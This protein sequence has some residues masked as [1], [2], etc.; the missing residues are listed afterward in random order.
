V[1][2]GSVT[3]K[4]QDTVV[5]ES[6][7]KG[8]IVKIKS[9]SLFVL[10]LLIPLL[11]AADADV[12]S[13]WKG[14][15]LD[16]QHPWIYIDAQSMTASYNSTDLSSVAY[17]MVHTGATDPVGIIGYNGNVFDYGGLAASTKAYA[18]GDQIDQAD[19]NWSSGPGFLSTEWQ[20][21]I[22]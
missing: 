15:Q 4:Q 12:I 18:K 21:G 8:G 19:A 9:A 1:S 14:F 7:E 3:G 10:I 6:P 22:T 5:P 20:N 11:R 2:A 13:Y 16:E 17:D